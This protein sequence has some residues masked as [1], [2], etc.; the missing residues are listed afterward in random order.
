MKRTDATAINDKI[1]DFRTSIRFTQQHAR[2]VGAASTTKS[3]RKKIEA[4]NKTTPG[5]NLFRSKIKYKAPNA[6]KEPKAS[7]VGSLPILARGGLIISRVEITNVATGWRCVPIQR[8]TRR[9]SK[10]YEPAEIKNPDLTN[11][12]P[13]LLINH[14]TWL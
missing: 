11:P 10:K 12:I 2:I 13:V 5:A 3:V 4:S 6:I 1:P 9:P 14:K 8:K 7:G